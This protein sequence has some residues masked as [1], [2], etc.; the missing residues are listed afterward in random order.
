M[1]RVP[2]TPRADTA[3]CALN[4]KNCSQTNNGR[5]GS[6]GQDNTAP[7]PPAHLANATFTAAATT[8]T[9][10]HIPKV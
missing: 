9:P 8:P 6:L 7:P 5:T 3:S 2:S 1:A 4:H 10:M